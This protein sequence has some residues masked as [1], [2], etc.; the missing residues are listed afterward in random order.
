MA[1][2]KWLTIV[3]KDRPSDDPFGSDHE[4]SFGK[5]TKG[6]VGNESWGCFK[7]RGIKGDGA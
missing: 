6:T 2:M 1:P 3:G 4:T 5:A 7:V